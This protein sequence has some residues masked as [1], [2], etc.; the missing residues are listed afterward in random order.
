MLRLK[1]ERGLTQQ[2]IADLLYVAQS[3]VATRL[4][5]L[6]ETIAEAVALRKVTELLETEG[7]HVVPVPAATGFDLIVEAGKSLRIAVDVRTAVQDDSRPRASRRREEIYELRRLV[8]LTTP[9]GAAE[10]ITRAVV[11]IYFR[12][13]GSV[14][15]YPANELLEYAESI[16][17][18]STADLSADRLEPYWE[19]SSLLQI[20]KGGDMRRVNT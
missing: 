5:R 14:G 7:L 17:D 20:W 4:A 12:A 18:F 6:E 9:S 19:L 11:A 16:P 2:Q 8:R 3:T 10:N 15:F 1:Y 13:D